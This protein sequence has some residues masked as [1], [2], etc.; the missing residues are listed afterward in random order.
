MPMPVHSALARASSS[1]A[2]PASADAVVFSIS[3]ATA[4]VALSTAAVLFLSSPTLPAASCAD[5][6]WNQL[7]LKSKKHRSDQLQ[8]VRKRMSSRNE[9]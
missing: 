9:Q 2:A 1:A 6:G 4:A 5:R 8:L 3:A 7:L